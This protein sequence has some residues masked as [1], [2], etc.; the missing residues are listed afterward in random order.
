MF[1]VKV[2]NLE[3]ISSRE[4]DQYIYEGN[5]TIIDLRSE[6][7]YQKQHI[8]GAVNIPFE[9]RG[10]IDA[11]HGQ[12]VVLYCERGSKSLVA[13]KELLRRGIHAKSLVG[14]INSYRGRF[15]SMN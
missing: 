4:L 5:V 12:V 11:V 2:M 3:T 15:L 14:G 10:D 9:R 1:W 8:Y 7:D 13:A 6:Q